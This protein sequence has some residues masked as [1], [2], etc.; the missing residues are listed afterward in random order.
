[1]PLAFGSQETKGLVDVDFA[2]DRKGS[3]RWQQQLWIQEAR[4]YTADMGTQM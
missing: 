1:M 4:A 3:L 2:V